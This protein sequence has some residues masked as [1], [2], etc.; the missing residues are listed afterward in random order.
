MKGLSA[1]PKPAP[2][3]W[4]E[5]I[6][7]VNEFKGGARPELARQSHDLFV[8]G[9]W[10]ELQTLF[11]RNNINGGWPPNRGAIATRE[12]ELP[13]NA[14]FD[15]YGGYVDPKTGRFRDSGT[16][17]AREDVPFPQRALPEAYND[18]KIKPKTTYRVLKP[19]TGVKQGETIP[20]FGQP[21]KGTQYELPAG[22][23][24]LVNGGY[25]EKV[26]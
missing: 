4:V 9:K 6:E 1:G 12:I 15:R 21:G 24:D 25:I 18:P 13:P 22:I 8:E 19:I 5:F 3:T 26:D 23:D 11:E 17:V 20:W 14:E 2:P 16:F 7:S 10:T